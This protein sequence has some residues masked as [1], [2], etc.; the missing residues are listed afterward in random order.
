MAAWQV[1]GTMDYSYGT[2]S[3]QIGHPPLHYCSK[4]YILQQM[5]YAMWCLRRSLV[6][7]YYLRHKAVTSVP[8]GREGTTQHT[9]IGRCTKFCQP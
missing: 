7:V 8:V 2:V 6:S 1:R 3:V 9:C 4:I 5:Q